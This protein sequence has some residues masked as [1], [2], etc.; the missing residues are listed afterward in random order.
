MNKNDGLTGKDR[1]DMLNAIKRFTEVD[2][3]VLFGSRAKGNYKHGS[4]VDISIDGRKVTHKTVIALSS[5]LNEETRM[6]YHFDII[7]FDSI[8]NQ[9][10]KDHIRRVGIILY[11]K[12]DQKETTEHAG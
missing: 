5:F 10:L 2:R 9:E 8:K 1:N 6:P 4:D 3:A 7:H 11:E 12:I